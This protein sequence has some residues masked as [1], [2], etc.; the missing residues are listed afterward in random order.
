MFLLFFSCYSFA[1]TAAVLLLRLK[2]LDV[3]F[4]DS[5]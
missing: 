4:S 3:Y 2:L 5:T 1:D